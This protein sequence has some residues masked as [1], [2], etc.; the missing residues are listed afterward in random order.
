MVPKSETVEDNSIKYECATSIRMKNSYLI[1][2]A[3]ASFEKNYANIKK[4]AFDK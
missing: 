4:R 1:K 2:N 3:N